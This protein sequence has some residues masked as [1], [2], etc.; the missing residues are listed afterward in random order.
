MH[1]KKN[2]VGGY[3]RGDSLESL[4]IFWKIEEDNLAMSSEVAD[5]MNFI[6]KTF[7]YKD[8]QKT[9]C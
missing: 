2:D 3:L 9:F 5:C 8:I 6:Y 1:S 4:H 7:V